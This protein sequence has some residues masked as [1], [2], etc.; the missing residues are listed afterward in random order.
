MWLS[1][2]DPNNLLA[3]LG[4]NCYTVHVPLIDLLVAGFVFLVF[5]I[6]ITRRQHP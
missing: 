1:N 2:C 4:Q 5:M 6:M 3:L